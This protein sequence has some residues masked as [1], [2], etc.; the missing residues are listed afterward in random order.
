M[1]KIE[2]K[3][4]PSNRIVAA[5]QGENLLQALL[6]ANVEISHSCGGMGTCGTCRVLI[7]SFNCDR[8][9]GR[10]EVES[11][12]ATMREFTSRER[13][14]CQIEIAESFEIEVPMAKI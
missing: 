10:T 12:I 8:L 14:A 13:L 4:L 2:I 9:A 3:I 11:E 5:S 7:N 1:A 6:K